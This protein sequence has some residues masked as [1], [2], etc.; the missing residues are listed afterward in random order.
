MERDLLRLLCACGVIVV[1]LATALLVFG[2]FPEMKSEV[3]AAWVQAFGSIA[4]IIGAFLLARSQQRAADRTRRLDAALRNASLADVCADVAREAMMAMMEVK[5][6]YVAHQPNTKLTHS[7][8]R[9]KHAHAFLLMTL[10]KEIPSEIAFPLLQLQRAVDITIRSLESRTAK[11][12]V[13][14]SPGSMAKANDRVV[15]SRVILRQIRGIAARYHAKAE[16]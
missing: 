3:W 15:K 10:G 14:I 9:L 6:L 13:T 4:A 2:L 5:K 12:A 16:P 8:N 7:S 11:A 1:L